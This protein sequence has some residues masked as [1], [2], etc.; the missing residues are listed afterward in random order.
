M[1]F[2]VSIHVLITFWT[3][4]LPHFSKTG[5]VKLK[6]EKPIGANTEPLNKINIAAKT[7]FYR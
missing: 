5:I 1:I 3:V 7:S 2:Y 4:K 6:S